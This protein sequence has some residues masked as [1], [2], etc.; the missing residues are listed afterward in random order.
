[1]V[2]ESLGSGPNPSANWVFSHQNVWSVGTPESGREDGVQISARADR[3][4]DRT[5]SWFTATLPVSRAVMDSGVSSLRFGGWIRLAP[6]SEYGRLPAA[7][8]RLVSKQGGLLKEV[9]S[10]CCDGKWTYLEDRVVLPPGTRDISLQ[11]AAKPRSSKENVCSYAGLF[12]IPD[13]QTPPEWITTSPVVETETPEWICPDR[14]FRICGKVDGDLNHQPLWADF[15]FARLL[16]KA[17]TRIPFDPASVKNLAV[18]PDG[19]SVE[20]PTVF[21]HPLST[22]TDRYVRNGTLKWRTVPG[23]EKYEIYFNTAGPEGPRPL[24]AEKPLGIGEVIRYANGE[25]GLLWVGWP[26]LDLDVCD[27]DGDGD[28]DIYAEN[29]DAGL[30]LMRNIGSNENP[31]FLPRQ[32][33]LPDDRLPEMPTRN[34]WADWDRDGNTDEIIFKSKKL[35]AGQY[36]DGETVSIYARFAGRN[37]TVEMVD[38]NS[39]DKIVLTNATWFQ[40]VSGDF[41]GDGAVDLAAGSS[42]SDLQIFLNR[43]IIDG[44]PAV[45]RL[46]IPL[47]LYDDPYDSGDMSLKPCAVD[48][49][50]DGRDDIV[51]TGWSGTVRLLINKNLPGRAEFKDAGSLMEIFGPANTIETPVPDAVDWD[52][53]GDLDL[54]CG[55]NSGYFFFIENI[56][57]S[58]APK[59]ASIVPLKD[60]SGRVFRVTAAEQGGT[61][62]G[63]AERWW[64]YTSCVAADVDGDADLD[65]IIGD[66]LGRL[67]WIENIGSRTKPVLSGTIRTF[68]T[69]DGEPVLTPWRNRP[70]VADWNADGKNE[71]TFLDEQGRLVCYEMARNQPGRLMN[72]RWF[73]DV[74]GEDV[75]V[76]KFPRPHRSA[77]RSQIDI[78]DWDGDGDLDILIGRPRDITHGGNLV[79]YEN[80][81][82]PKNPVLKKEMFHAR[83][84]RFVEWTKNGC[85]GWETVGACMADWDG[86]GKMDLVFGMEMGRL[87]LYSHDYFEGSTFPV[88]QADRFQIREGDRVR[89][90]FHFGSADLFEQALESP[91]GPIQWLDEDIAGVQGNVENPSIRIVSPAAGETV[92]GPVVFE[93]VGTGRQLSRVEFFLDGKFLAAEAAAPYVAFGD[94]GKWDTRKTE[95]G[96]HI[97][98]VTATYFDGRVISTSQTNRVENSLKNDLRKE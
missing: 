1:M 57:N 18:F 82:T 34:V 67:R 19:R 13:N 9:R 31:L 11:L 40:V 3:K 56:G 91:R 48:W 87:T 43:G 28:W 12:L 30:W 97:L 74:N 61:V 90:A 17:G 94:T 6:G 22:L 79:F 77:G 21:D 85:D 37:D 92:S 36:I 15:D 58:K 27:A 39:R 23:A 35:G 53:D 72:P 84:A 89:T 68:V 80:V 29:L 24:V 51:Y 60:E 44:K 70:D 64:G 14:S 33:P 20:T 47:N 4:F 46:R 2:A 32:R 54:L 96:E 88:F 10:F 49:N 8:I 55:N 78:G 93:A 59:W 45:E 69:N 73:K 65:V 41:D 66:S 63:P 26:G 52:G 98:A 75:V 38:F 25:K 86:D 62:Q 81:G 7:A 5:T 83:A 42:D 71:I 50:K 76:N 95:N 16:L